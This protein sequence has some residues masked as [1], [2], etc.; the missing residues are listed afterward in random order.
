[1]VQFTRA[2]LSGRIVNIFSV[3]A[4]RGI[5]SMLLPY[6]IIEGMSGSPV[7]TYHNG[8]K[9]VGLATG[10]QM[11]RV[12]AHEVM[13]YQG[14]DREYRETIN[15]IVEFG[16]AYHAATLISF[17]Q[18]IWASPGKTDTLKLGTMSPRKGVPSAGTNTALPTGVQARGR[19]T[20]PLFG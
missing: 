17:L 16:V 18:E 15:R 7:L 14:S 19:R 11:Q 8:P 6:A 20:L 4:Q 12:V 5:H 3:D 1:M 10:N 9:L 2:Y 13:D